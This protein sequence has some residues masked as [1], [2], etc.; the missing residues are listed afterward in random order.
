ME[1]SSSVQA[2]YLPKS[3]KKQ[4]TVC[5]LGESRR[6]SEKCTVHL[7]D[8]FRQRLGD[9]AQYVAVRDGHVVLQ[10]EA[11]QQKTCRMIQIT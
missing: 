11:R 5:Y 1:L 7:H 8:K 10:T 2:H 9:G 4:K 6:G 3:Y